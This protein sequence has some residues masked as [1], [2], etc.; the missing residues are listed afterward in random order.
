MLSD[1]FLISRQIV[2]KCWR[3]GFIYVYNPMYWHFLLCGVSV[4]IDNKVLV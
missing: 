2:S 3:S 1:N 4:S